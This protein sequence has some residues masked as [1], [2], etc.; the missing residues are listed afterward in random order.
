MSEAFLIV[1][2]KVV[3]SMKKNKKT[4]IALA[5]L[6]L[7]TS[8]AA[9]P[10]AVSAAENVSNQIIEEI[11]GYSVS[12]SDDIFD[13][14][15]YEHDISIIGGTLN[16]G[17][18]ISYYGLND[19]GNLATVYFNTEA[20]E[21]KGVIASNDNMTYITY[22]NGEIT[23]VK[24]DIGTLELFG[25][26]M[27]GADS[28]L[29][30]MMKVFTA[31]LGSF[32]SAYS[33]TV[34]D[35]SA[36]SNY[37]KASGAVEY[38]KGNRTSLI[39]MDDNYITN[40]EGSADETFMA[41]E[42]GIYSGYQVVNGVDYNTF[43]FFGSNN[44]VYFFG[45]SATGAGY[46]VLAMK[47]SVSQ[48]GDREKVV[49]LS[50]VDVTRTSDNTSQYITKMAGSLMAAQGAVSTNLDTLKLVKTVKWSKCRLVPVIEASTSTASGTLLYSDGKFT[51]DITDASGNSD[52]LSVSVNCVNF[53]VNAKTTGVFTVANKGGT[54]SLKESNPTY[55]SHSKPC[56]YQYPCY[57]PF[58][59]CGWIYSCNLGWFWF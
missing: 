3:T 53:I 25:F 5:V 35:Y 45:Y 14:Y 15:D 1:Y 8:S 47:G 10:L 55:K 58:W 37:A 4:V 48:I 40:Q 51:G 34:G 43:C 21:G 32:V 28:S 33:G 11:S 18:D 54:G 20:N 56:C 50:P 59:S 42:W 2:G 19:E 22:D 38:V 24:R 36:I 13:F 7:L 30:G 39:L 9:M 17:K 44:D 23:E 16:N 57:I 52:T 31:S 41:N 29:P 6:S 27:A 46:R 26:D 12:V 49:T